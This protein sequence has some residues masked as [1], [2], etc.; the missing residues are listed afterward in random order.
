[1]FIPSLK[2]I[3]LTKKYQFHINKNSKSSLLDVASHKFTTSKL[4]LKKLKTQAILFDYWKTHLLNCL[5][6]E[7]VPISHPNINIGMYFLCFQSHSKSICL[8][9]II[10]AISTLI[11]LKPQKFYHQQEKTFM[12]LTWFTLDFGAKY[13][14]KKQ[15]FGV[16]QH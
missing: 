3:Y 8:Q 12:S 1:M 10:Q 2:M 7:R 11:T 16:T 14:Y 9:Q 5:L 4:S 13:L 6:S 15:M